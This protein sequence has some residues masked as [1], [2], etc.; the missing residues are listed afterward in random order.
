[1]SRQLSPL[2]KSVLRSVY[3]AR[4]TFPVLCRKVV[5][6]CEEGYHWEVSTRIELSSDWASAFERPM[7][8]GTWA[9]GSL[10]MAR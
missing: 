1:M 6:H 5:G 9:F 2:F 4:L 8:V 3:F 10:G 7:Q